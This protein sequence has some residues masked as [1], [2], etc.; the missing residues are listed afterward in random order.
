MP[1]ILPK[2]DQAA[3]DRA[4]V[5]A[6]LAEP[7]RQKD[8][9]DTLADELTYNKVLGILNDGIASGAIIRDEKRKY[10]VA[11]STRG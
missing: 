10:Q 5:L 6:I 2:V 4:K 11:T 7:A 9:I 3:V 1:R 8:I